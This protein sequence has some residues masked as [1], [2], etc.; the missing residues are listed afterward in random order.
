MTTINKIQAILWGV[1]IGLLLATIH[2]AHVNS[3]RISR[4]EDR[5]MSQKTFP[6]FSYVTNIATGRVTNQM[7]FVIC[8]KTNN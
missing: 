3:C 5:V 8:T 7:Y 2:G 1:T 4:I 6:I